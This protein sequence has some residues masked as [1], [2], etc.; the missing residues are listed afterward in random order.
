[1]YPC[2]EPEHLAAYLDGRLFPEQ[3]ERLEEHLAGCDSCANA[4]AESL[5]FEGM[6][7]PPRS[8]YGG[9]WAA[10]AAVMLVVVPTTLWMASQAERPFWQRDPRAPLIAANSE[11]RPLL[12]R[13]TGGFPWAP[14]RETV[15]GA[16]MPNAAD[17]WDRYAA[18]AAVQRLVEANP[19]ADRLGALGDAHLVTGDMDRAVSAMV[20]AVAADPRDARLR[21]DLAAAYL[22]RGEKRGHASDVA[23]AIEGSSQA[24][25]LDDS[26]DEARF[27]RA[28]AL[29]AMHLPIVARRAWE[30]FYQA[31]TDTDWQREGRRQAAAIEEAAPELRDVDGALR[32]AAE[33][34]SPQLAALVASNRFAARQLVERT[35]LPA[36]ASSL[37]DGDTRAADRALAA[38]AAIASR[39]SNQTGDP[40]LQQEIAEI[41]DASTARARALATA[42]Q[43]LAFGE[44][45]LDSWKADEASRLLA[46]AAAGF[47]PGSVGH[48]RAQVELLVC[49]YSRAGATEA[50]AAAFEQRGVQPGDDS[51]TRARMAWMRGLV[52]MHRGSTAAA[53][54]HYLEALREHE[55]L[56]ETEPA[57]WLHYLLSE[58]YMVTGDQVACWKERAAA[59][60]LAPKLADRQRS[61]GI[62]LGSA[63]WSVL[64]GRPWLAEAFLEELTARGYAREPYELAELYLWR[65]R[66][67]HQLRIRSDVDDELASA[68]VAVRALSEPAIRR[69]LAAELAAARGYAA[70]T[71]ERA[72]H[73]LSRAL[74][75]FSDL[76]GNARLPG[77]LLQRARAYRT[78]GQLSAAEQDL[79]RG[80]ALL[81][82]QTEITPRD[83][84]WLPRLDGAN[85]LYD[86]MVKLELDRGR[87]QDAFAWTERSRNQALW[88]TKATTTG[89]QLSEIVRGLGEATS[90]VS[91]VTLDDR[92]VAWRFD[93]RG[94]QL[95]E[96][97]E[98]PSDLARTVAALNGDLAAGEWTQRTREAAARLYRSLLEPLDLEPQKSRLVVVADGELAALPFAA[99]VD[100]SGA[101]LIEGREVAIA[102][103]VTAYLHGRQRWRSLAAERGDLLVLADP[104]PDRRLFPELPRLPGAAIEARRVAALY[105][106]ASL[107]IGE[108]ATRAALLDGIGRHTIVH[109]ATHALVDDAY[110]LRSALALA[111]Q[112]SG[113]GSGALY[114]EEVRRLTLPR[115]RTVVLAACGGAPEGLVA[116][117]RRLGLPYAFLAADVPTVVASPWPIGDR[118]SVELLTALH[119]GLRS[120]AEPA[121]A[122]RAA[123]LGLLASP[124]RTRRSPATWALFQAL[125]G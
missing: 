48:R 43:A 17:D 125:G 25:A 68:T 85:A 42:H 20:R 46:A 105:P 22:A 106:G 36:W 84:I 89:P 63:M 122:L 121:A 41:G 112:T 94:A 61:F 107:A 2:P 30:E 29:Q 54:G 19:T 78:A 11:Q 97:D 72:I 5:R 75:T 92:V 62:L 79:R 95:V 56:G 45:A 116:T 24:L 39:F 66:V 82:A 47:G 87:P 13:L 6:T 8:T 59:V 28:L 37:L 69:R 123:Q 90:L 119:S 21:S 111:P 58:A 67:A 10:A 26:L 55:R 12:P 52:A 44:L 101:Y 108:S 117:G 50:V 104:A 86:E 32:H 70:P 31:E 71:P 40:R 51:A 80:I 115:T 110:P 18:A 100:E 99:L 124:D 83:A 3:R 65:A 91:F 33:S 93:H 49:D 57:T 15:R 102:P 114:A 38:A 7:A 73:S 9:R 98:T 16:S 64:G 76:G 81:E 4:I 103:S 113:D 77:L 88:G 34:A 1:L 74:A 96:I 60:A 120:G 109:L 14:P 53:I 118:R 27:N 35:L 23:A